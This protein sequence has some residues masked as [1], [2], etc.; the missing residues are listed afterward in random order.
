MESFKIKISGM[1]CSS[2]VETVTKSIKKINEVIKVEVSLESSTAEIEAK[3]LISLNKIQSALPNK[4]KA[5][6]HTSYNNKTAEEK[7]SYFSQLYPL[8]LILF[9]ISTT[10][11]IM[12]WGSN[13]EDFM[14]D[15]MG[16]FFIVFSFFKFLDYKSFPKSFS[17]YD[18]LAK[19]IPIYGWSYPIIETILGFMFLFR[20]HLFTAILITI[21][22]LSITTYGVIKTLRNKKEIQC[23]C[24]GTAIKLPMTVA[25]LIENGIMILMAIVSFIN[26]YV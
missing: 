26:M 1:T 21:F 25:T 13:F 2:C 3:D 23:A 19:L 14:I 18:P 6:S 11:I 12:N 16:I 20:F 17:M 15:F 4:F 24:L 10:T 5:V 9:Y 22:L 8:I 7:P